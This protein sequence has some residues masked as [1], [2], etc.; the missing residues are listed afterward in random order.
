MLYS[1][2]EKNWFTGNS[3]YLQRKG[4]TCVGG[5]KSLD[6]R[7]LI[8]TT[9]DKLPATSHLSLSLVY[10]FPLSHVGHKGFCYIQ[11]GRLNFTVTAVATT[12]SWV[13]SA[14]E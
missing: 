10:L 8:I 13:L 6:V 7:P 14:M 4:F 12:V 3:K 5:Y 11:V 2:T 1:G 9:H